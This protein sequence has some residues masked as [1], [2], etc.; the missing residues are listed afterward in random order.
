MRPRA[1]T[2]VEVLAALLLVAIGMGAV[3]TLLKAGVKRSAIAQA[4]ALQQITADALVHTATPLDST[5]MAA[6]DG[7]G[8]EQKS[9]SGTTSSNAY[10]LQHHGFVN[11]FYAIRTERSHASDK[12]S[13]NLRWA[14]VE[15][16]L[17][18]GM[19]GGYVTTTRQRILR[20][21]P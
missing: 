18:L 8:W 14:E 13:D 6:N 16:E 19:N 11:G 10:S 4:Q 12:I 20:R 21:I 1:F 15:V 2:L 9:V 5:L 7:R 17:Y 3:V